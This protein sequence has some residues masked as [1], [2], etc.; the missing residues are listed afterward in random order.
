MKYPPISL[1]FAGTSWPSLLFAYLNP[2]SMRV[3]SKLA[4]WLYTFQVCSSD[5]FTY[6]SLSSYSP[7]CK[8][9]PSFS[10][11]YSLLSFSSSDCLHLHGNVS[12]VPLAGISSFSASRDNLSMHISV[13]CP[14][15]S[16]RATNSTVCSDWKCA[17]RS[18]LLAC[19]EVA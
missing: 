16:Q 18:R 1:G 7:F 9:G 4:S 8:V 3:E 5:S 13:T 10:K 15:C 11:S 12:V 14:V 6:L 2:S 19:R 17:Q